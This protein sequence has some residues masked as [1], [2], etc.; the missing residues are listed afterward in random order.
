MNYVID[1]GYQKLIIPVN[2]RTAEAVTLLFAEKNVF[3]Y[4]FRD[5]GVGYTP[6]SNMTAS[7]KVI[8]NEELARAMARASESNQ[9]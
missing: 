5:G 9:D 4:G 8:S 3:D 2:A 1:Y 6:A 7:I